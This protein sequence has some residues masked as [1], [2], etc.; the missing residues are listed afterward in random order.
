MRKSKNPLSISERIFVER[1]RYFFNI[2][3]VSAIVFTSILFKDIHTSEEIRQH[4]HLRQPE[5]SNGA[6]NLINMGWLKAETSNPGGVGRPKTMY[7]IAKD[8]NEI[9]EEAPNRISNIIEESEDAMK[10]VRE[11]LESLKKRGEV[12]SIVKDGPTI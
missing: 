10:D 2:K 3:R 9:I 1:L 6:K 5:V 8:V 7:Y 12:A 11:H 4:T